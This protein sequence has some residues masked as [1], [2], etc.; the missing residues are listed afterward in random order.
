MTVVMGDTLG[1]VFLPSNVD[2]V[3]D[4]PYLEGNRAI[5][6]TFNNCVRPNLITRLA[7][8]QQVRLQ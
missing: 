1:G 3:N 5:R 6:K 8:A 2:S 4:G 7:S